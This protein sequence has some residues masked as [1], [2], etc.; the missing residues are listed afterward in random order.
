MAHPIGMPRASV[1]IDHFHPNFGAVCRVLSRP[2]PTAGC[3]VQGT[4]ECHFGEVETDDAVVGVQGML[5]QRVEYARSD[6]FVTASSQRRV[7]DPVFENRL[8]ADPR[9]A[10][11]QADEDPPKAQ[12]IRDPGPVT[13]QRV[14]LGH[15][16]D[17][18]FDRCPDGIY[19][20]GFECADYV[21][22]LHLVVGSERTQNQI[23]ALTTTGGWSP[24][25]AAPKS[26]GS[27]TPVHRSKRSGMLCRLGDQR[28][29]LGGEAHRKVPRR[30]PDDRAV[31]IG[32]T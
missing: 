2:F 27:R 16:R 10:G 24:I 9:A 20:F 18:G 11:D 7:R 22:D 5:A 3:L 17:Q 29:F 32:Q 25:R 19:H 30:T 28:G 31:L 13:A 12:P 1:A 26:C 21:G 4:V 15:W 8:D 6:P 14:V 23:W